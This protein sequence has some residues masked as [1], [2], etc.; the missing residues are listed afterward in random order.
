MLNCAIGENTFVTR[1]KNAR[2]RQ[3]GEGSGYSG[4]IAS[5]AMGGIAQCGRI[6]E[7]LGGVEGA[8]PH[9]LPS[10]SFL[11]LAL[12]YVKDIRMRVNPIYRKDKE[13]PR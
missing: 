10:V 5:S 9:S 1:K 2:H 12:F 8:T 6:M 13:F 11:F 4:G 3:A 7:A